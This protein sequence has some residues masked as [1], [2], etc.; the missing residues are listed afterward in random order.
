MSFNNNNLQFENDRFMAAYD[1]LSLIGRGISSERAIAEELSLTEA[2]ARMLVTFLAEQ[3]L[4]RVSLS[5]SH[6]QECR[7]T[8][9]GSDFL[10]DFE[11]IR[12]FLS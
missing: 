1:A 5:Y 7:I 3:G 8:A 4:V 12:R 6:E 2:V 10:R 11:N 9:L